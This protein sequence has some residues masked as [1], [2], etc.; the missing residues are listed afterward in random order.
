M[1]FRSTFSPN[2]DCLVRSGNQGIA[3]GDNTLAAWFKWDNTS[4]DYEMVEINDSGGATFASAIQLV[5]G[6]IVFHQTQGDGSRITI[7]GPTCSA[8][9]WTHAAIT[10]DGTTMTGYV[11]GASVGTQTGLGGARGNWSDLQIGP[12]VGE[13][14]DAVF[15]TVALTPE[16]I[17]Q[18]YRNRMPGV[19]TGL[20]HHLPCF[21]GATNRL[22][23]YSGNALNFSNNG[24]PA[25]ATTAPQAG[26]G[27]DDVQTTMYEADSV[28]PIEFAGTALSPTAAVATLAVRKAFNSN[29]CLSPSACSGTL[30]VRKLF[31]TAA[32]AS[33]TACTATLQSR[34]LFDSNACLSPSSCTG[35]LTLIGTVSFTGTSTSPTA[36]S[37]T[38]N[39]RKIAT[40]CFA[41]SPTACTGT[42]AVQQNF[43]GTALSP[44]AC[45]GTLRV[46]KFFA[47]LAL[48]PTA[49]TGMQ[50]GGTVTNPPSA[51]DSRNTQ[52]RRLFALHQYHRRGRM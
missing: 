3:V 2:F 4:A 23:D 32:A 38:F 47:A 24:T 44:S 20:R 40:S 10:W 50:T 6:D 11:D 16:Q 45:A 25:E 8:G 29:A 35:S 19:R 36:C 18:L 27:T 34:K 42:L 39:V 33:P 7:V 43:T 52:K 30:A 22:I 15:Y 13:L 26:W 9:V 51:E 5:G 49:C 1:A 17:A 14:Q 21:P 46:R 41:T 31:T 12:G 48:S 28:G 37:A